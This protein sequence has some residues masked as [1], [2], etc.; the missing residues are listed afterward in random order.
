MSHSTESL[1]ASVQLLHRLGIES[2]KEARIFCAAMSQ[3]P[4]T[5][6]ELVAKLRIPYSTTS[7]AVYSLMSRGLITY[8]PHPTDGR[9]KLV[10]AN[11]EKLEANLARLANVA[12]VAA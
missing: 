7:W 2:I 10:L 3:P 5:I 8:Q 9:A 4:P 12:K 11:C 6:G 1:A